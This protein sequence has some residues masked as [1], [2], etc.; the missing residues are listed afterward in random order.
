M[1]IAYLDCFSGISGDMMLGALVDAGADLAAIQSAL[2]PMGLPGF[3]LQ[4]RDVVSHGI[5][6]TKVDVHIEESPHH[7]TLAQ[8]MSV[9]EN[10][11]LPGSTLERIAAIFGFLA[12]AEAHVHGKTPETIHFH[13]VGANDAIV[14][15]AGTCLGIEQ[16]GLEHIECSRVITGS[17]TFQCAHGVLPIPGPAAAYLLSGFE[18]ESG[19]VDAELVTPTGAAIL[20]YFCETSTP[21]PRMKIESEGYGAGSR[22]Y[23]KRANVLRMLVGESSPVADTDIGDYDEV[24]VLSCDLDDMVP[25]FYG[26]L[27]DDLMASGALDVTLTPVQMKKG[28]PGTHVSVLA[29]L[30]K[31]QE[32]ARLL[33]AQSTTIGVRMTRASRLK[34][35]RE[36]VTVETPMGPIQGK[37][38]WGHGIKPRWSPEYEEA[39][40]IHERDGIPLREI[41]R[42]AMEAARADESAKTNGKTSAAAGSN[43]IR[44]ES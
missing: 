23:K 43:S 41:Y 18:V 16:L 25:E 28:R 11:G 1:K 42:T 36:Q 4:A 10:S 8:V 17:G 29:P 35:R 37:L 32:I 19:G 24:M 2:E 26:S 15:V 14:D 6:A 3:K 40:K 7:R 13:E 12:E 22:E 38:V 9:V 34:L 20:R 30:G 31:E 33:L 39:R 5:R 21:M 27:A 44:G